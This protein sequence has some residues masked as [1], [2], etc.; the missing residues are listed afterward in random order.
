[1]KTSKPFST[2]SYNTADFLDAKLLD[3]VKRRKIDFYAFV[4]HLPEVDEKK[5][6]KHLYIVPNGKVDTD[7][8][9]DYLLEHDANNPTMPLGCIRPKSSKFGDWYLYGLHD[10]DYLASK[11]QVRQYVYAREEF[12]VSDEDYF[13]EE[14][15]QIDMSHLSRT[16]TLR[17]AVEDHVPF[18]QMVVLGQIPIQ[19]INA[20]KTAYDTIRH[21][22]N[23]TLHR[24][25]RVTHQLEESTEDEDFPY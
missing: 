23:V 10:P 25:G 12:H 8:V 24:N 22:Q 7:E 17:Q 18:E 13:N 9:V 4:H 11:G 2:I 19:Q 1:M 20:Y 6:H 3:L 5:E 16:K 21:F 14:I 15:H